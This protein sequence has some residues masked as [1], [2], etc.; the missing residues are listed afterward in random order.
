MVIND[1]FLSGDC[2]DFSPM[3]KA[4]PKIVSV[5]G[6]RP[7]FIKLAALLR[8]LGRGFDSRVVHT[9][10]H[11]DAEMSDDFFA[12]YRLRRPDENLVVGKGAVN[13]QLARMIERLDDYLRRVKPDAV[14]VFGDTTSTMAGSLAA[15][16][17]N[18][19]LGHVESGLRSFDKRMAEERNR[20][21]ADHL[22]T[23]LFCPSREAVDNLKAEGIKRGICPVG[24]VMTETFQIPRQKP[25]DL[26]QYFDKSTLRK[27]DY[28]FVTVHRAEAVDDPDH[29]ARLIEMLSGLDTA[30]VF[31]VHPRTKDRLKR[32]DLWDRLTALPNLSVLPPVSHRSTLWLIGNSHAVLTDSGGVQ[33]EA[34]WAGVRCFT[35]RSVTEW[36]LLVKA[37][38][39]YLVGFSP[40]KL[41]RAIRSTTKPRKVSDSVFA[42]MNASKLIVRQLKEDVR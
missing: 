22:S 12:E 10:Q 27:G 19:P 25:K 35:L 4:K 8:E 5:V 13:Q 40:M 30:V 14:L 26:N 41:R 23:W 20:V 24:D 21:V 39:N 33:K 32:F 38:W 18:I 1:L 29:L 6:A 28:Y 11:Y 15:A 42:K 3:M 36:G 2:V 31:P 9:G 34:Y 17:R 37:G 7:Q 16:A